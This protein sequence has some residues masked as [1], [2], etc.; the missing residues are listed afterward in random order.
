MTTN[1]DNM[2]DT[3]LKTF[4]KNHPRATTL[5]FVAMVF[6]AQVGTAAA[7]NAVIYRGP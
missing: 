7:G 1:S 3:K 2:R 5:L 4:L 6:L